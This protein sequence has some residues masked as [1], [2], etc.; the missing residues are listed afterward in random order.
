MLNRRIDTHYILEKA[1]CFFSSEKDPPRRDYGFLF[2]SK[3]IRAFT[4]GSFMCLGN[5][6]GFLIIY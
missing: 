3:V 2:N 1:G 4:F 6:R 5:L